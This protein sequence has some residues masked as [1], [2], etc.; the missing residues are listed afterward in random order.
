MGGLTRRAL[1]L[2]LAF[3]VA[4]PLRADLITFSERPMGTVVN[5][6]TIG[7]VSFNFLAPNP[8]DCTI[9]TGPGL[10]TFVQA[11]LAEGNAAGML[12]LTFGAPV[13]SIQY[14]FALSTLAPTPVGSTMQLFDVARNPIGV[15]SAP[16]QPLGSFTEGLVS[17]NSPVPIKWAMCTFDWTIAAR[18]AFDNLRTNHVGGVI[19]EPGTL[20]LLGFGAVALRRRRRR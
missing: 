8:L 15:V 19:P 14:G 2:I 7:N 1:A 11:P 9:A 5:G 16:G 10:T 20:A 3:G 6:L 13:T 17:V 12:R 18:F 4:A